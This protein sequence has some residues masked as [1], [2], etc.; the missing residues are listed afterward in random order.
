MTDLN[1]D[2]D[3]LDVV[4]HV[5]TVGE[6]AVDNGEENGS[7][8]SKKSKKSKRSKKS[9]KKGKKGRKR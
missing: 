2:G 4:L 8:K 1:G 9:K 5:T 6:P 3:A 7:Y